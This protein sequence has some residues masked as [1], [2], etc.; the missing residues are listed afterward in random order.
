MTGA[1]GPHS[2]LQILSEE[3]GVFFI[4]SP[5]LDPVLSS[6]L[7]RAL[8]AQG[9]EAR[10]PPNAKNLAAIHSSLLKNLGFLGW[11]KAALRSGQGKP[12]NSVK[13]LV[14]EDKNVIHNE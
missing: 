8:E 3:E 14:P 6:L 1:S 13:H 10:S 11:E 12:K 7:A 9:R 4:S 2:P 5:Y